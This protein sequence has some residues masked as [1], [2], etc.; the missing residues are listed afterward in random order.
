M[1]SWLYI[2]TTTTKLVIA[3]TI[4]LDNCSTAKAYT[5]TKKHP[6]KITNAKLG[7]HVIVMCY[8]HIVA[9][10]CELG[11]ES[12][13]CVTVK[14]WP[15]REQPLQMIIMESVELGKSG[16]KWS[17]WNWPKPKTDD[18]PASTIT[19]M[20]GICNPALSERGCRKS[21]RDPHYTASFDA[22]QQK[23]ECIRR[24][25]QVLFSDRLVGQIQGFVYFSL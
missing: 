21:E 8:H 24:K 22:L 15:L 9:K 1:I 12:D 20:G 19:P 5:H 25:Y 23:C 10:M 14:T 6:T 4:A 17:W 2:L 7:M 13:G 11:K 16:G 18:S 3:K